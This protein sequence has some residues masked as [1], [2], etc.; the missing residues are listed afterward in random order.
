MG[1]GCG[2]WCILRTNGGLTLQLARSLGEAGYEAWTP[3]E[4]QRRRARK[5]LKIEPVELALIPTFVFARAEHLVALIALARS[6][7]LNYRVWDSEKRRM[8]TKG[9]PHFSVFRFAGEYQLVPDRAL[10]AL[11][12]AERRTAPKTTSQ[13][14]RPG[15]RVKLTEGGFAGL[16]GVVESIDRT[17]AMVV[18]P[19]FNIA[20]KIGAWMLLA[21]SCASASVHVNNIPT[22]QALSAKAA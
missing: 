7:S 18:F 2:D 6:P 10:A 15:D 22:E 1:R 16:S 11:R 17:F 13:P 5:T 19:G 4:V 8:V 21:D 3:V 12:L 9:H 20:V 14:F